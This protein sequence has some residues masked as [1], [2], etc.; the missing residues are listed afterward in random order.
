MVGTQREPLFEF[1]GMNPSKRSGTILRIKLA[2][3]VYQLERRLMLLGVLILGIWA[4]VVAWM[5]RESAW[6]SGALLNLGCGLVDAALPA[7]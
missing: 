1:P 6:A 7:I 5:V 4:V 2:V 3:E